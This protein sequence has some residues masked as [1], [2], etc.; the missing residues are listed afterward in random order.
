[1]PS[2]T[3]KLI[4]ILTIN[5]TAMLTQS[6]IAVAINRVDTDGNSI[7]ITSRLIAQGTIMSARD[8]FTSGVQKE[9]K[10]DWDGSLSDYN[11][12]IQ[13]NPN[14]FDA[15]Y[16]RAELKKSKFRD[17]EGAIADYSRAIQLSPDNSTTSNIYNSR[18]LV[19]YYK[20]NDRSGGIADIRMANSYHAQKPSCPGKYPVPEEMFPDGVICNAI[21]DSPFRGRPR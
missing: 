5:I 11:R 20:L 3:L 1:M 9:S 12:A 13:L 6:M 17:Y 16:Y 15:F 10:R 21:L 14:Y 7:I 4:G 2:K 19:K 18:G 8:Y